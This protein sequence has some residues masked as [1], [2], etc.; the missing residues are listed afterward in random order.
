MPLSC[1]PQELGVSRWCWASV[2]ARSQVRAFVRPSR[3][4]DDISQDNSLWA[5]LVASDA[6]SVGCLGCD[7]VACD[8]MLLGSDRSIHEL[9]ACKVERSALRT[10]QVLSDSVS[11][12]RPKLEWHHTL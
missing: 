12:S 4:I 9:L 11:C 8:F 3:S 6:V 5:S 1:F 2:P 10:S 7:D